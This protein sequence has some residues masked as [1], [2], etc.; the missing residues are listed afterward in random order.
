MKTSFI[1][2][3]LEQD[4]AAILSAEKSDLHNHVGTLTAAE[5]DTIR[6]RGLSTI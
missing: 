6:L 1:K 4:H 3:L 5:L 2:T